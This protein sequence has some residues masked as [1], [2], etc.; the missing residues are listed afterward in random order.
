MKLE[1]LKWWRNANY[2][3]DEAEVA[4]VT[5]YKA[6]TDG[7]LPWAA[8]GNYAIRKP[9]TD[10]SD[11]RNWWCDLDPIAAQAIIYHLIATLG[12]TMGPADREAA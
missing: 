12:P 7:V 6:V 5:I 1:E 2:H 3:W 8:K 9:G 4:G 11:N 10:S